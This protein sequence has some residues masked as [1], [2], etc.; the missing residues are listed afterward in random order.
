MEE[1][2]FSRLPPEKVV[3]AVIKSGQA[4]DAAIDINA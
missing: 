2:C 1:V 4:N 3:A